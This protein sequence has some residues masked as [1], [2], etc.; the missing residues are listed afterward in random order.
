[1]TFVL[2]ALFGVML[3]A[4]LTLSAYFIGHYGLHMID[5]LEEWYNSTVQL[6]KK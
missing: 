3:T 5:K 4:A 6:D 1:M 2:A